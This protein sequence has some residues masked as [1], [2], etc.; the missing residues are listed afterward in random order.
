MTK[1]EF[2]LL[3]K[4]LSTQKEELAWIEFKLGKGSITNEQIG[5]YISALSN[6]ATISNKQF[7]YLAWGIQNESHQWLGTNF[8]FSKAKQGNQSL[9]LWLRNLLQPKINFEVFE[10]DH[11]NRHFVIIRIPSASG[12]P[13]HFKNRAYIRI[14]SNKTEIKNY[15]QYIRQ[16]YN[17]LEDWSAKIIDNA[18]INDLEPAAIK[19]ARTKFFEKHKN[20]SIGLQINELDDI[21]FLDKAKISI[22]G[23]ITRAAILL[24]GKEESSHYL[25][26][27]L[28]QL[29]WKLETEE[30]AYE[31]FHIPMLISTTKILNRIRNIKYKFFPDHELLATEVNKYETRVILEALHNCIAHQDYS[32]HQR[33][34]ITEKIDRLIF[35]NGGNFYE[36]KPEDYTNGDKTPA[37]YRNPWLAN[38]MVNLNMIDT[39]GYGIHTM[40]LE[41]RRRFFPLP[42]YDLSNQDRVILT[43]HGHVIDENYS[44]ILM[45]RNDL[46]LDKV[47]LLDRL[48]KNYT[49]P[50]QTL[51]ELKKE[52]LIEG[53]KPN[54]FISSV[55]ATST[56]EKAYYIKHKAFDDEHYK[57][58]IIAFLEKFKKG[59]RKDFE[60]LIIDK[61]SDMLTP[62]QKKD[63]IK[64]LLQSLRLNGVISLEKGEWKLS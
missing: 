43:V 32:L 54:Y 24:L 64:N 19:I 14:G 7:G 53:R 61:L 12:E 18:S 60:I 35:T 52:G 57:K 45:Q 16:I 22:D 36:G 41:Q 37:K 13:T 38:A 15:P 31:H 25:L 21:S 8:F 50:E 48:Q 55:L 42:D 30:K 4:E 10:F 62:K 39:L 58:L 44:K 23:K 6:G 27:S 20:T 3:L 9:E 2:L 49:I 11:D 17:T 33:I 5:E 63:K 29:T 51:V 46:Y 47:I 40:F 26:P 59:K 1:V 56:E 34:I 28:M